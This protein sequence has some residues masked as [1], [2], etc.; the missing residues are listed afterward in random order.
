MRTINPLKE[1]RKMRQG[2]F[3][4]LLMALL[5]ASGLLFAGGETHAA[6]TTSLSYTASAVVGPTSGTGTTNQSADYTY[7]FVKNSGSSTLTY[8]D[9]EIPVEIDIPTGI[10]TAA[11]NSKFVVSTGSTGLSGEVYDTGIGDFGTKFGVGDMRYKVL[12][13]NIP[14]TT[15]SFSVV[16]TIKGQSPP[17]NTKLG[18]GPGQILIK[19][20]NGSVTQSFNIETPAI[21]NDSIG[22]LT[23]NVDP[24]SIRA[25]EC[26]TLTWEA[27]N[28]AYVFVSNVNYNGGLMDPPQ[29]GSLLL[30]END[31]PVYDTTYIL[32]AIGSDGSKN[33]IERSVTVG[34][35]PLVPTTP[36]QNVTIPDVPGG[37]T[38]N[39]IRHPRSGQITDVQV[40]G[41]PD[42]CSGACCS[43]ED[44]SDF[45]GERILN[46]TNLNGNQGLQECIIAGT[47]SPHT[48]NVVSGT[49][50]KVYPYCRSGEFKGSMNPAKP[51]AFLF[52]C[53]V[54]SSTGPFHTD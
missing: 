11:G 38:F 6:S 3:T 24:S 19:A 48:Q 39:I 14:T 54:G 2:K 34:S 45:G 49:I 29:G 32:T 31:C 15:S 20:G 18:S 37:I 53:H 17:A 5:F 47:G 43:L 13:V 28:A 46:C 44:R 50:T 42:F 33:R 10:F 40:C 7:N 12:K 35:P 1:G 27:Q 16:L 30:A 8:I 9:F 26:P 4:F 36:L 41:D 23:F 22:A 51:N 52:D 25:G 21:V